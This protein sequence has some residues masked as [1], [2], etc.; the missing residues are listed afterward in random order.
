M[1]VRCT[2][3]QVNPAPVML[4]TV[5]LEDRASVATKAR[6]SSFPIEVDNVS[7]VTLFAD[8]AWSLAM[9]A[10]MAMLPG[11]GGS[12]AITVNFV[13]VVATNVPEI[14]TNTGKVTEKVVTVKLVV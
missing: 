6:M 10:S 5:V 1:F 13:L 7:L 14:V 12:V 2:R 4:V 11:A 9:S 8:T 3:L